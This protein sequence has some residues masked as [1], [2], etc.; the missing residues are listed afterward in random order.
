MTVYTCREHIKYKDVAL[1]LDNIFSFNQD[2]QT[3]D[4]MQIENLK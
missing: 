3:D 2:L 1:M 4:S